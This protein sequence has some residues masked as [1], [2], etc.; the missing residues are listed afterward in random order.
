MNYDKPDLRELLAGLYVLRQ[1]RGAARARFERLAFTRTDYARAVAGWEAR[2]AP[3]ALAAASIVPH[4]VPRARV[5]RRIKRK[6]AGDARGSR[7][8][9][10]RPSFAM[11][12]FI[13]AGAAAAAFFVILGLYLARPAPAPGV[14]EVAV[15]AKKGAPHWLITLRDGHMHL[16][17]VGLQTPPPGKSYQ[18]WMLPSGGAQ[19]VSLGL[20]P[21]TGKASRAL[22][23]AT[24]QRLAH[25]KGLAVSVEPAGGSP[26]G[27]PTGPVV[28]TAKLIA[29]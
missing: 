3:L 19:P 25:A 24:R 20:L 16:R 11:A 21:T 1:L 15:I 29:S 22:S 9:P 5:W 13:A 17:A 14:S 7:V 26:T 12:G 28:Y 18:L 23:G 27:Q 10:R 6:I 4:V 2:L 8:S